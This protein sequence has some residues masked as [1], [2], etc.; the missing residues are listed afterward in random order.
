[1]SNIVKE[2]ITKRWTKNH[3]IFIEDCDF[4][5]EGATV[6]FCKHMDR[7]NVE[8]EWHHV[9]IERSAL[10]SFTLEALKEH[11]T[12]KPDSVTGEHVQELSHINETSVAVSLIE[13]L[14]TYVRMYIESAKP[15]TI[16]QPSK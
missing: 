10:E 5:D 2:T 11:C 15:Y 13:Y 3:S 16:I 9:F 8:A 6:L 14:R 7:N 12:D 4:N 1:M